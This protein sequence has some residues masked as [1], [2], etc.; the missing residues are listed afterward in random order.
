MSWR[1]TLHCTR[2]EAEALPE[3][4]ELFPYADEPPVIVADEPD[5]HAPDD[6]R[7]HAYF[8]EQPTTQEL[9]LLR[10]LAAGS[11]P[12][13][14][15]LE[16]TT[17]WVVKSQQGLEPI[18]AGRFFVHTPM[19]FADRPADTINFEIDAG[20]AFGTGQHDTTAGCLAALDRLEQAGKRFDNIADIGTG[21]GL[22]AFAAMALWPEAKAIATDIDPISIDV[23]RDNALINGVKVG[24]GAGEV[25][26]AVSDGM[27]HPLLAARA[28]F[29]LLI[30]NILAGPLIELAPSFVPACAP[31]ASIVLAGLLDTQ[32]D[33]VVAAYEAQGCS[34]VERGDG[35]WC[36]LVLTAA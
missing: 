16:D 33:A 22:L 34:V 24:H 23:T 5:P 31:G 14:E 12:E 17:D 30:A 8:A 3:S 20:L 1:V 25:L 13:V 11:E 9:I 15:H 10:R 32:A 4:D 18:R 6:W 27:E 35:E 2:A 36:V 29:D 26:L 21:T 19:H 28:P 7:I